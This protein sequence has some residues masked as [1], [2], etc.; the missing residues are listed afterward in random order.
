[1]KHSERLVYADA[2]TSGGLLLSVPAGT[3]ARL[4]EFLHER[5]NEWAA[6]IGQVEAAAEPG[7]ELTL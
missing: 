7:L 6:V 4:V 1:M 2:I 5:G 3:G